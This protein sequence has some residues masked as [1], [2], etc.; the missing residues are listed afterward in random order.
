MPNEWG[1]NFLGT[2]GVVTIEMT[3][4]YHEV[5]AYL[6]DHVDLVQA[7]RLW[8]VE[9]TRSPWVRCETSLTASLR[10]RAEPKGNPR[11]SRGGTCKHC[12]GR[13]YW[14]ERNGWQHWSN[15]D[16]WCPLS[17]EQPYSP[18]NDPRFRVGGA[19]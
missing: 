5:D 4:S 1:A 17:S 19:R 11:R 18:R 2:D 14:D 7:G 8:M 9:R 6:H 12:D 3:G 10:V 13:L 16:S 15:D